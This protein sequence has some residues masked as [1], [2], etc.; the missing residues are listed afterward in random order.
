MNTDKAIAFQNIKLESLRQHS[1]RGG[2][3]TLSS[4]ALRFLFQTGSTMIMARLL[5]PADFGVVAMVSS[6]L[7]F[8]NLLKDFGLSTAIIQKPSLSHEE[9]SGIFGLIYWRAWV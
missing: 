8:V 1:L 2:T 5:P 3:I 9:L 6:L 4:Q 7:G